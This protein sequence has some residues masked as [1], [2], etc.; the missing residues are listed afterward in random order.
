M[1][2]GLAGSKKPAGLGREASS[3]MF[4]DACPASRKP[5]LRL[6]RGSSERPASS[7]FMRFISA[8]CSFE[9]SLVKSKSAGS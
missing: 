8:D 7:A 5:A 9:I 6:P 1:S 4:L 3:R 2:A